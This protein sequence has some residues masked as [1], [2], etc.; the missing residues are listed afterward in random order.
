[1]LKKIL[2]ANRGE[3]AV[4]V[5]RAAREMG[6]PTV[7]VYSEADD[8]AFHLRFADET[9]CIGP[10]EPAA[11]YL[12]FDRIFEAVETTGADAL[13]PGYGFLAENYQFA[14]E[15]EK[16]GI[17][18]IGSSSESIRLLGSKTESRQAMMAAGI[19]LIPGMHATA[20]STEEF[21][22]EAGKVGYPVLI[23]AAG[24]GGGKGMRIVRDESGLEEAVAAARREAG[25]AFGNDAVYLEK[26]I[27]KPRHVEFQILADQHGNAIHLFE[28]ECSIQRR[29]QKIVEESPSVAL[30]PELR[31]RM[32]ETAVKVVLASNYTN[33]GTVEFLLDRNREFY[34]LEVNT[35]IQVEHPVTE[36]I[37]GIDLVK[38]QIRIAAG[39]PLGIRQEDL[40]Q[41]GH[42]IE[43]RVYAEDPENNFL[44]CAGKI[45]FAEEPV[46]PGI[47]VDSGIYS[48][49]TVPVHY[50]PI[51]SKVIVWAETRDE[52]IQKMRQALAAYPILGIRTIVP[53]LG[54]VLDHPEFVGGN[55]Y[56]DFI[57][58]HLKDWTLETDE[59]DVLDAALI[60]GALATSKRTTDLPA[61]VR[62]M[63]TP[64]ETLGKW[65]I[66]ARS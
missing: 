23:K 58:E 24:G 30:D 1:M 28:R 8:D 29:H 64:W 59:G 51:L 49:Y 36:L 17:T 25:S 46:G 39:E 18:F 16:Q 55:T 37:T 35:R 56:T 52:A 54:A 60:A 20:D 15:C 11:S 48:G 6:I 7:A 47:R 41:R 43:C 22:A 5:L 38:A 53:F 10:A 4:R 2:V 42:A 27:E 12:N 31:Q 9:V 65:E 14:Q 45:L 13:H 33:A 34:F 19:P 3:I 66:A 50:D 21:V 26:L 40:L 62:R 61:G 57:D 32:G 63:P 44:P